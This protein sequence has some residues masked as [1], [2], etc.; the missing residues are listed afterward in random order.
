MAIMI[1]SVISPDVK[2]NAEKHIFKWFQKAP[3]TED[4]II[5]HSLGVSNHKKVIHGEVDFFAL[6]PERGIFALEV[7]GGRVR[8]QNGIWSFTD[9]YGHTDT[10]E[11][12]PFDQAWEGIY[13]LKESIS[14]ML[15]N[16][17]RG[18][19]DIIFGI[20]VM[21]PDVEY[22]SIGVDAESWQIFDSSDGENVVAFISRIS[23]GAKNTWKRTRGKIDKRNIPNVD[24]IKYLADLLRGDFDLV[25]LLGTKMTY[26]DED[27]GA[28]TREQYKCLDQLE[29]NPRC[30]VRGAAGTGKT[31]LAIEATKNAIA[32]G[33]TVALFC[34]NRLLG[35][36]LQNYFLQQPV[37]LRPVYVGTLHG[38]MRNILIAHGKNISVLDELDEDEKQRYFS[39]VL[40]QMATDCLYSDTAKFDRIIVDEA[41][42][43]ISESYLNFLDSC[44]KRG[45]DRGRWMMFGDLSM[46][47]I[48]GKGRA[49]ETFIAILDRHTSFARFKL[50]INCRNTKKICEEVRTITGIYEKSKYQKI[51]DG[52]PV[53]YITY[54]GIDDERDKL[55]KILM[56][57]SEN[58]VEKGEITI[59]SPKRREK[60][61]VNVLQEI[62]VPNFSIPKIEDFTFSTIQAFKGLENKVVILVD[63]EHFHDKKL[64]YVGLS[65]ARTGLYV[66]ETES[67]N[68]EYAELFIKRRL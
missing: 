33:E 48:Y 25:S 34:F 66:L 47:A 61:V 28:L 42:D 23:E 17:H 55:V 4:W 26:S 46:Q 67:G 16:E 65:R 2:S 54:S 36:W 13:S 37:N 57:L 49:E 68:K 20:G 31:M 21:F 35:E 3:G 18:L 24:D 14:K 12:G 43:I 63:I 53:Q 38:Y 50:S 29:D 5:L 45:I 7:K 27:L 56:K 58:Q 6:I 19:K 60:S 11:R 51:I 62:N 64:M 32:N 9:K 40:P 44:I 41:Q 1:P 22:S 30:L 8:R 10:K 15:D 59:L 39:E 52:P